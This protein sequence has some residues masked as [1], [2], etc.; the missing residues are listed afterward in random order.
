MALAVESADHPNYPNWCNQLQTGI[1]LCEDMSHLTPAGYKTKTF[2][3]Q[4]FLAV[5]RDP[6]HSEQYPAQVEAQS[7]LDTVMGIFSMDWNDSQALEAFDQL[8]NTGLSYLDDQFLAQP[9]HPY[10]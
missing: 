3:E 10:T 8:G 6:P 2:M 5:F 4:L 1:S 7:Q 9:Y